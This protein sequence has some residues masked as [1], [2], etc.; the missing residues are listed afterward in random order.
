MTTDTGVEENKYFL[1]YCCSKLSSIICI[2][3]EPLV[4]VSLQ[5]VFIIDR[6]PYRLHRIRYLWDAAVIRLQRSQW[7]LLDKGG[8]YTY[9]L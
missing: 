5:S 8:E 9:Y 7:G 3:K 6:K 2:L 4:S 1:L